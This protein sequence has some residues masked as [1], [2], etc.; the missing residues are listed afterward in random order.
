MNGPNVTIGERQVGWGHPCFVVAEAGSAH[1]GDL[2][3]AFALIETAGRAGADC[4]K[5]QMIFADEIVHPKTGRIDLPGGKTPIYERFR[6]LERD[7]PFYVRLKEYTEKQ[8]LEF[9]CSAFGLRSA[10]LLRELGARAVKIASPELNHFPLLRELAGYGLPLIFS[11]GV[12]TLCDIERALAAVGPETVLL[13][14]IT[15]YPAPEEEY[16]LRVIP[17]LAGIFGCPVGVSD[18]SRDP[19]LVPCL[20][21]TAGACLIEKH[22]TLA[23]DN[24][25]LDDPI[26]LDAEGFARMVESVRR[27]ESMDPGDARSWLEDSFGRTRIE[28]TLGDGV[29]RLASSERAYYATTNRTLHARGDI[30]AGGTIRAEQVCVVRSERNLRPGIG[31]EYLELVVGR[32]AQ[33]SIPDGQGIT[34]EDLLPPPAES[35]AG[36]PAACDPPDGTG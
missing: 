7:L 16:N 23:A 33:R 12:S 36:E 25:G 32:T 5:F 28:R 13:H 3:R 8:G 22:I 6:A 31:P 34:W 10:H 35:A 14:C 9:L 17:H 24:G 19:R 11:T 21:V 2:S 1:G 4:V 18:H 15:A 27:V 26:A 20:A 30:P 29:K